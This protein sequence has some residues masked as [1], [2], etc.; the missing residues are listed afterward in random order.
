MP[1]IAAEHVTK[2][3]A[4]HVL[5]RVEVRARELSDVVNL[6][7]VRMLELRGEPRLVEE[8][9]D[10]LRVL[11]EVRQDALDADEL[12]EAAVTV[13]PR[14]K[15]LGHATRRELRDEL[16]AAKIPSVARD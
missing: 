16:V 12:L 14:E 6:R 9:R 8:H 4:V 13:K 11:R 5:H 1:A 3:F 10:E 7:D 15:D 2:V